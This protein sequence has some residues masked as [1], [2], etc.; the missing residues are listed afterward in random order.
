M[1]GIRGEAND[2][3]SEKQTHQVHT[4]GEPQRREQFSLPTKLEAGFSRDTG[5]RMD[6]LPSLIVS[7]VGKVLV[8]S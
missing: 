1:N 4:G 2:G 7:D 5:I 3:R 6:L 8:P